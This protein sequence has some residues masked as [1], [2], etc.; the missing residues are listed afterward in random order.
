MAITGTF[1]TPTYIEN[2]IVL[3]CTLSRAVH[4]LFAGNFR[5]NTLLG[6]QL[7]DAEIQVIRDANNTSL[8][9]V[10]IEMPIGTRGLF[11]IQGVGNITR[12][13]TL[14][15][16]DFSTA[17]TQV[18]FSF[19]E[20]VADV[21]TPQILE[22]GINDFIYEWNTQVTDLAIGDFEMTGIDPG[23]PSLY[24]AVPLDRRPPI[25]TPINTDWKIVTGAHTEPAKY[26]LLR[27]DVG[28]DRLPGT[29]NVTL[30]PDAVEGVGG[31]QF[32]ELYLTQAQLETAN[33]TIQPKGLT[34][35]GE[36]L[37]VADNNPD[38]IWAFTN[39]AYDSSKSVPA[40]VVSQ[41]S[42]NVNFKGITWDGESLAAVESVQDG[43]WVFTD[44][45]RDSS[46]DIA[47]SVL[48]SANSSMNPTGLT[49]DGESWRV[50]DAASDAVYGF[51]D[52]ARDSSKD[53]TGIVGKLPVPFFN[54]S[55]LTWI[56]G[57]L[58]VGDNLNEAIWAFDGSTY[59][60]QNSISTTILRSANASVNMIGLAYAHG[61]LYFLD[62]QAEN[63]WRVWL[64]IL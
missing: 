43:I 35:D 38:A 46:K 2:Q 30:K 64:G 4:R 56:D 20:P 44:G 47:G 27:F 3:K 22:A 48:R 42:G 21:T 62:S 10:V 5:I 26:H 45:A 28:K 16:D 19:V 58:F 53:V 63:I 11:T 60:A 61:W 51:T 41:I 49:W 55:S 9:R 24:R 34:H 7:Y 18:T 8:Y 15:E 6:S 29:L 13:D 50:G 59:N 57:T 36:S 1:A 52:G 40:S 33:S 14:A 54:I 39:K 23:T 37:Y 32:L 25:T 31:V 17:V 12:A